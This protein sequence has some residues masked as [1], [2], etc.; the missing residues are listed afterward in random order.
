MPKFGGYTTQTP[1]A[2]VL[3]G[4]LLADSG[5]RSAEEL[6]ADVSMRAEVWVSSPESAVGGS[7]TLALCQEGLWR[8]SPALV[9]RLVRF[10]R[11]PTAARAV[12]TPDLP[13]LTSGSEP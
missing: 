4:A 8:M 12:V 13:V 6:A 3:L 11:T 9:S 7:V 2:R 5:H 10:R 1:P